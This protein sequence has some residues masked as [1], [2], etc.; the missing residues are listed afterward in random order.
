MFQYLPNLYFTSNLDSVVSNYH[1]L[2]YLSR[3]TTKPN[4][5][6]VAAKSGREAAV[7]AWA[8]QE[9]H[10]NSLKLIKYVSERHAPQ[11]GTAS[12]A[13]VL[14]LHHTQEGVAGLKSGWW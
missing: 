6:W 12:L 8:G 5:A 9:P 2:T 3:Q 11:Y 10:Q 4:Q 14:T 1:C 7:Q 13:H